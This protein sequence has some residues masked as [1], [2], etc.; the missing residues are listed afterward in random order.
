MKQPV[1]IYF[2]KKNAFQWDAYWLPVDG[3]KGKPP[4]INIDDLW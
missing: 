4:L 2:K 1:N 3:S